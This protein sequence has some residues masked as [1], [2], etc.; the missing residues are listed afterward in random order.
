MKRKENNKWSY[1][2]GEMCLEF[3]GISNITISIIIWLMEL[4]K[5]PQHPR[6]SDVMHALIVTMSE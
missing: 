5:S 2:A 3:D 6:P 1:P 4:M